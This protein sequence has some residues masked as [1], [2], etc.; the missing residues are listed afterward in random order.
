MSE[1]GAN[2]LVNK[3]VGLSEANQGQAAL[4]VYDEVIQK[5]GNS[6]EVADRVQVARALINKG[7][8]LHQLKRPLEA[9]PLYDEALKRTQGNDEK[10]RETAAKAQL[11]KANVLRDLNQNEAAMSLCVDLIK[12]IAAA[13]MPVPVAGALFTMADTLAVLGKADE[14]LPLY[15]EVVQRFGSHSDPA[16]RPVVAGALFSKSMLLRFKGRFAEAVTTYDE[17]IKRFSDAA[18]PNLKSMAAMAQQSR[19]ELQPK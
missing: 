1:Q 15:D 13:A 19:S 16:V 9:L 14:A 8:T 10:L 12:G 18:E 6:Q 7:I 5:Y 2:D 11:Q 17:I 4:A 3:G